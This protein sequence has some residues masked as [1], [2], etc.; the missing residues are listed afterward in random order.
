M[1]NLTRNLFIPYVDANTIK[2]AIGQEAGEGYD[3]VQIDKSTIFDLAFNPQEETS[4]YIDTANDTTYVKS[5]QPELPQEIILDNSNS[6]FKIM[7]PFCMAMPTGGDAIVPVLLR[8]PNMDT[9]EPSDATIWEEA[10]IS[11]SNLNTVDGKLTFSL[12]LNGAFKAGT[13]TDT[14]GKVTF[15]E[16]K[17]ESYSA[18][19]AKVSAKRD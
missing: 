5:Y 15:S 4:G 6:L 8:Q 17:A 9:A 12:K 11:P 1:A 19:V 3:W 2:K 13:V 7:Y 14:E 10:L 18:P 16:V